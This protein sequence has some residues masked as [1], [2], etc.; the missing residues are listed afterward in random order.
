MYDDRPLK[1]S[2]E[3]STNFLSVWTLRH[4]SAASMT[5]HISFE[6]SSRSERVSKTYSTRVVLVTASRDLIRPR[7]LLQRRIALSVKILKSAG[8]S[9]PRTPKRPALPSLGNGVAAATAASPRC[10]RQAKVVVTANDD[11]VVVALND[12]ACT[13]AWRQEVTERRRHICRRVGD[14]SLGAAGEAYGSGCLDANRSGG[15]VIW[16]LDVS[17]AVLLI[18]R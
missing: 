14:D 6:T 10:W 4:S 9:R 13:A 5:E 1:A 16:Q 8:T 12:A 3:A 2:I 11:G 7:R 18:V 15:T 17:T